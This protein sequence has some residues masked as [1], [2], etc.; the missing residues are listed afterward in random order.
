M[1]HIECDICTYEWNAPV[2]DTS[3]KID[4]PHCE[5][6]VSFTVLNQQII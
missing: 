3:V 6:L 1:K 2:I 5:N 4:C